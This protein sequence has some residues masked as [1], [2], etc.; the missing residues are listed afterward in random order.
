MVKEWEPHDHLLDPA[1]KAFP[2]HCLFDPF[3]NIESWKKTFD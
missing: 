2:S 3:S 1:A